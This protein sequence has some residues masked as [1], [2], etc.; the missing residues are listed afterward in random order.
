MI[1]IDLYGVSYRLVMLTFYLTMGGVITVAQT[2]APTKN[3]LMIDQDNTWISAPLA[4]AA[5]ALAVAF[6]WFLATNV[7]RQKAIEKD[8]EFLRKELAEHK[9]QPGHREASERIGRIESRVEQL[10]RDIPKT[11]K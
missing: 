5:L 1:P 11:C 3:H 4:Y 7:F 8:I 9:S 2:N 10:E 6:T